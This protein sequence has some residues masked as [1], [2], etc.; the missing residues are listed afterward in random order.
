MA[1]PRIFER[2]SRLAD[3]RLEERL[4]RLRNRFLLLRDVS[5][6]LVLDVER[7]E[8]DRT[9]DG[10]QEGLIDICDEAAVDIRD[11]LNTLPVDML[12]WSEADPRRALTTRRINRT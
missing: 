8:A 3:W 6:P 4:H 2:H 9:E 12:N 1:T 11:L 5:R 7:S 10:A